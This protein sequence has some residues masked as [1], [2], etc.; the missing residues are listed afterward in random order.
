MLMWI[1]EDSYGRSG[2]YLFSEAVN[3]T[4]RKEEARLCEN[5]MDFPIISQYFIHR[6]YLYIS[7]TLCYIEGGL[8]KEKRIIYAYD[9]TA[10]NKITIAELPIASGEYGIIY[11]LVMAANNGMLYYAIDTYDCTPYETDLDAS[12][13]FYPFEIHSYD[14]ESGESRC[15]YKHD[16]NEEV[17]RLWMDSDRCIFSTSDGNIYTFNLNLEEVKLNLLTSGESVCIYDQVLL[18]WN[19][20]D[21]DGKDEYPVTVSDF[22]G[23]ELYSI[24]VKDLPYRDD[25]DIETPDCPIFIGIYQDK[26]Y[27]FVDDPDT[28]KLDE[29]AGTVM[30]YDLKTGE[31]TILWEGF[32]HES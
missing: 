14:I 29:P 28:E 30:A 16:A 24:T 7:G 12:P 20:V 10:G 2:I 25:P 32:K 11:D 5:C 23:H 26:L 3:G 31:R 4:D 9:I 27:V 1:A 15:L 13:I 6:G 19:A 8:S 22:A 17:S 21:K 18:D